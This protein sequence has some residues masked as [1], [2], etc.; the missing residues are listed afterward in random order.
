MTKIERKSPASFGE[1]CRTLG[2]AAHAV[3]QRAIRNGGDLQGWRLSRLMRDAGTD[4]QVNVAEREYGAWLQA[5][6]VKERWA[7]AT[8]PS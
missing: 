1:R 8:A 7:V 5:I 3:R 4:I 6:P 2:T